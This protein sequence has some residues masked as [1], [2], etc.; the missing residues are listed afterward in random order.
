MLIL[1]TT[2]ENLSLLPQYEKLLS[3]PAKIENKLP[4]FLQFQTASLNV[5]F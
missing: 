3:L 5:V 1:Q 4:L 2:L